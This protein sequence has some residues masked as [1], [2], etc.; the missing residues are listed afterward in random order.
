M[1]KIIVIVNFNKILVWVWVLG[2]IMG[3]CVDL[4][5]RGV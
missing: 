4:V 1:V 2:K 5:I 3:K